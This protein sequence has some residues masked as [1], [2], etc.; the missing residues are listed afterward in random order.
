MS[1]KY[2]QAPLVSLLRPR[3]TTESQ[4]IYAPF[5][6]EGK[7]YVGT[8]SN[9]Y[10]AI[11]L[12]STPVGRELYYKNDWVKPLNAFGFTRDGVGHIASYTTPMIFV[13]KFTGTKVSLVKG[14]DYGTD[15]T[16][17]GLALIDDESYIFGYKANV[18]HISYTNFSFNTWGRFQIE[19]QLTHILSYF[20]NKV[21]YFFAYKTTTG[22]LIIYKG[23]AS[24]Q[25]P[26]QQSSKDWVAGFTHLQIFYIA[27]LPHLAAYNSDKG[28]LAVYTLNE[29]GPAP[30]S[31]I[32]NQT[33]TA[34][35]SRFFLWEGVDFGSE[36]G[37][38]FI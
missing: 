11:D 8:F 12:F 4:P 32:P 9:G 2:E 24:I 18:G 33:W 21:T 27:G 1:L 19:T 30:I 35:Y 28:T 34:Q 5:I 7:K 38:K 37:I 22:K 31:N 13:H 3:I 16:S 26:T 17:F 20:V 6:H 10:F 15:L 14:V 25:V 36:N 23:P 29:D